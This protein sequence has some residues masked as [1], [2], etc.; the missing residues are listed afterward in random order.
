M[1]KEKKKK[2]IHAMGAKNADCTYNHSAKNKIQ[3]GALWYV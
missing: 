2:E 1:G 3:R